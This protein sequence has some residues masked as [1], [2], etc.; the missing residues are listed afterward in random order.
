MKSPSEILA[1]GGNV[2]IVDDVAL[3]RDVLVWIALACT[4]WRVIIDR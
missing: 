1:R 2:D 4:R 3:G